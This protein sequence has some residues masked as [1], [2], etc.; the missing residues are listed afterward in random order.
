MPRSVYTVRPETTMASGLR[1]TFSCLCLVGLLTGVGCQSDPMTT[2][3]TVSDQAQPVTPTR[4]VTILELDGSIIVGAAVVEG[5]GDTPVGRVTVP[6][7][8]LADRALDIEYRLELFDSEHRLADGMGRWRS[9][10]IGPQVKLQIEAF[11][12]QTGAY[13][14]A[15]TIRPGPQDES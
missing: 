13:D 7:E 5:G 9:L 11:A 1:L 4:N 8:S 12:P 3:D 10:H 14:W 6:I 2:P 15:L